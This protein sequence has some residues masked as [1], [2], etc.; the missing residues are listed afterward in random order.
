M[1]TP[2][3]DPLTGAETTGHVWDENLQE[4][5]NPLPRWWL[6]TFYGTIV[7]AVI[8]WI[9]YPSWP[10]AN[11]YLKGIGTVTYQTESGEEKTTHWNMRSLFMQDMQS[12]AE[13]VK[14]KEYLAKVGS[15]SYEQIAQDSDMSAFVRQYGKGVFGDNCAACHQSGGQGVVGLFPNLVDD[16]WLWGGDPKAIEH[17]IRYGRLGYMPAY[18]ETLDDTQLTQVANYVLSLSGEPH[19][20]AAAA[21]GQKIFQG[22]TGGC[23]MCH[24]KEGKGMYSQGS[25]NLTDKIWTLANVPASDAPEAKLE[26]VKKLIHNGVQ[27]QMP[28]FHADGGRS[29]LSDTE[30][31]V[32]VAYLKQMAAGS[33]TQ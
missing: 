33:A 29:K 5:N 4:F 23:Y 31:K 19:D 11:T 21:E 12:S 7:F 24:T 20:A 28:A 2:V 22:E 17:T 18:K 30:I 9:F 27:R 1:A 6:W 8:Y 16:D 26:A 3:K 25:A 32:L 15:A 10:V 14:Q 13:A